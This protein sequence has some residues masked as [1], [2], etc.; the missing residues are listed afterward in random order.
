[1]TTFNYFLSHKILQLHTS[2]I[3][4]YLKTFFSF[5]YMKDKKLLIGFGFN[6]L[7]FLLLLFVIFF[8]RSQQC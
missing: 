2:W 8:M 5:N 7:S 3:V 6:P 4:F 1:M